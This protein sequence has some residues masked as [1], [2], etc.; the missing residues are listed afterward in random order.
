ML[1]SI[2]SGQRK[3]RV[4][5][6][7]IDATGLIAGVSGPDSKKLKPR[8]EASPV[9]GEFVMDI[10]FADNNAEVVIIHDKASIATVTLGSTASTNKELTITDV[11]DDFS[12]EVLIIGSDTSEK[13]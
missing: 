4:M 1:R 10:P 2:K 11:G 5:A 3:I 8:N 12:C 7:K 9:A 13:Y 6:L